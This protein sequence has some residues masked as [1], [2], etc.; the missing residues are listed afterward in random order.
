MASM[1]AS[2]SLT[3]LQAIEVLH[4]QSQA[5][6]AK[7]AEALAEL[8]SRLDTFSEMLGATQNS[9]DSIRR[10]TAL[11]I[12]EKFRAITKQLRRFGYTEEK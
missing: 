11:D 3:T 6:N 4:R 10:G 8:S 2:P 7:L 12:E 1:E 5:V 9:I